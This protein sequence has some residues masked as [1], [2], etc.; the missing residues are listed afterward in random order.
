VPR[1][2]FFA[3]IGLFVVPKFFDAALCAS[4]RREMAASPTSPAPVA[5]DHNEIGVREDQ[6]KCELALVS[7]ETQEQI[8]ARVMTVRPGLEQ[9]FGL[10]LTGCQPLSFLIYKEGYYFGCH[11]DNSYK[12]DALLFARER[13]VSISIF[14]NGEGTPDQPETYDGGGLTFHGLVKDDRRAAPFE[15]PLTGEE[16]LLIGFRSDM[17][18]AVQPIRRGVRYSVV[19][20]FT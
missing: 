2:P 13:L 7:A 15:L 17:Y 12:D 6:R 10:A 16:G 20:W 3:Q 18:H 9:H 11:V 14:L 8:L 1:A 5:D 19:A 4:L